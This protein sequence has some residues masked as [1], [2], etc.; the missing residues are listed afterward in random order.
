MGIGICLRFLRKVLRNPGFVIDK[1]VEMM[2]SQYIFG[3]GSDGFPLG[4][5]SEG[6]WVDEQVSKREQ[7]LKISQEQ[8]NR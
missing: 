1:Y 7:S 4:S 6:F 8:E 2:V 3:W 5:L